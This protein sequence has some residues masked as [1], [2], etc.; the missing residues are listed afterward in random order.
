MCGVVKCGFE[1]VYIFHLFLQLIR[2][3]NCEPAESFHVVPCPFLSHTL[4]FLKL[5]YSLKQP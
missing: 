2:T 4:T 3:T 5:S 1:E